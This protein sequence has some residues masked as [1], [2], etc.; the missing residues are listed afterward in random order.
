M[1]SSPSNVCLMFPAASAA[2]SVALA[3]AA[4][5]YAFA[6]LFPSTADPSHA[7]FLKRKRGDMTHYSSAAR[8]ALCFFASAN[9]TAKKCDRTDYDTLKQIAA[10][11]FE[12]QRA[13]I[14]LDK[15]K[16]AAVYAS[17][18]ADTARRSHTVATAAMVVSHDALQDARH[19]ANA[20]TIVAM[21]SPHVCFTLC[22]TNMHELEESY[23]GCNAAVV[24]AYNLLAG[25]IM[26]L[27]KATEAVKAADAKEAKIRQDEARV[28]TMLVRHRTVA[29]EYTTDA[30][31]IQQ[32]MEDLIAEREYADKA[33]FD[34]LAS[35]IADASRGP[36]RCRAVAAEAAVADANV[37]K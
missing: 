23:R 17:A 7:S 19:L 6:T 3:T 12:R 1:P 22:I 30:L 33:D 2:E 26:D 5:S 31:K 35:L 27:E 32:Q 25:A 28:A 24:A 13:A 34:I 37:N 18:A 21:A 14:G 11:K 29:K 4:P 10:A 36:K 8:N 20:A 9:R 16:A 15:K